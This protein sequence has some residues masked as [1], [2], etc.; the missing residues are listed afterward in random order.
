MSVVCL[1]LKIILYQYLNR[2]L[3]DIHIN[4]WSNACS[5]PSLVLYKINL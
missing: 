5:L 2:N 4:V 3:R 1:I